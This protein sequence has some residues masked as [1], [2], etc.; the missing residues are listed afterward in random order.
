[1]A[2]IKQLKRDL[3]NAIGEVIEGTM[4]H[5]MVNS[6]EDSSKTDELID[7]SI[8]AFD[9]LISKINNKEVE[10]RKKHLKKVNQ[11]IDQ[12][13]GDLVERLNSL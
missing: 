10:N 9:E 12:K 7:D 6:K 3:N 2:S 4:I 11:D 1:M 8:A 5:Q 13:L